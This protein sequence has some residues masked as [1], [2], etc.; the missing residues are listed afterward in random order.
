MKES[1]ID[2]IQTNSLCSGKRA[3]KIFLQAPF[4]AGMNFQVGRPGN[5]FSDH[6]YDIY[7]IDINFV[8]DKISTD[9]G[10]IITA[11]ADGVIN[12]IDYT[13]QG[14]GHYV[15]IQH[16]E[17]FQTVYRH[18]LEEPE[19]INVGDWVPQGT[20]IGRVGGSGGWLPHLH[21]A[22]Y[23]CD[24]D[25]C[26]SI[27]HACPEPLGSIF[28]L[29][30]GGKYTSENYGIGY[31]SVPPD[32]K[33]VKQYDDYNQ[34][35]HDSII[36]LYEKIKI[37]L[38][39]QPEPSSIKGKL[40]ILGGVNLIGSPIGPVIEIGTTF[41]YQEFSSNPFS[42]HLWTVSSTSAI[43][44]RRDTYESFFLVGPIWEHYRNNYH[45]LGLPVNSTYTF[46][47]ENSNVIEVRN[48]FENGS[49]LFDGNAVRKI[50]RNNAAWESL[51]H[52]SQNFSNLKFTRFDESVNTKWEK[53]YT[54]GFKD[55]TSIRWIIELSPISVFEF[56]IVNLQGYLRITRDGRTLVELESPDNVTSHTT[57]LQF[58]VLNKTLSIDFWQHSNEPAV[59]NLGYRS[60]V[61]LLPPIIQKAFAE[62]PSTIYGSDLEPPDVKAVI[63]DPPEYLFEELKPNDTYAESTASVL[64]LDTSGSM[65]ELDITGFSKIEAAQRATR[66]ILDVI[67]A[68]TVPGLSYKH[69]AG[70][71]SFDNHSAIEAEI[72]DDLISVQSI[73]DRLTANGG[74]G[75]ADGL[76]MSLDMLKPVDPSNNKMIVL[77][78]DGMPNIGLNSEQYLEEDQIIEQIMG[79]VSEARSNGICIHAVGL[80][81]PGQVG[82]V[83]GD[84]S[85]NEDLLKRIAAESGC[86]QYYNATTA[87]ELANVFI[88]I[89][90]ASLGQIL[91]SQQGK[92]SQNQEIDLGPVTVAQDQELI[93][94]TLN[95][96]GSQLD[97]DVTDPAG[98]SVKLNYPNANL[99]TTSSLTSLAV[100][101]PMPG[102]WR[103]K[104]FG[105][106]VPKVQTDYNLIFSSRVKP[107]SMIEP[108]IEPVI[109]DTVNIEPVS[110]GS[111][112]V[113]VV[114][115]I[116]ASVV[117]VGTYAGRNKN[118]PAKRI[119][120]Q[121]VLISQ[122]IDTQQ[123]TIPLTSNFVIGRRPTA[124]IYLDD[125]NISRDHAQ[126]Y[127]SEKSW[128]IHDLNSKLGTYLNGK[129]VK[130]AKLSPGDRIKIGSHE[131]I[132]SIK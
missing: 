114:I 53:F 95:W 1:K 105:A 72:T 30:N 48:D 70:L 34:F 51:F 86:G 39:N 7:G 4:P 127:F 77:L 6:T 76:R 87:I 20:P 90:H 71:V 88:E 64:L 43:V 83:S 52:N 117:L 55:G 59:I 93:L 81:M 121:A 44:E 107:I 18:L 58:G 27:E 99:K 62:G 112:A 128:F 110:D 94:I 14:S 103:V 47:M 85:I 26:S 101:D 21:F 120:P 12:K 108:V 129:S 130:I 96:P 10:I 106:D 40:S 124:N 61:D 5:F 122:P 54:P 41:N 126:I 74:T 16:P 38:F 123:Q 11:A 89:R 60:N 37:D 65:D 67:M 29:E 80:G 35:R 115:L 63:F 97:L 98:V 13:Q 132:F 8:N 25:Y 113:L 66:S 118:V 69:Q 22:V 3:D 17:G 104:V 125:L 92:I 32:E 111:G 131:W 9:E 15:I 119:S 24:K 100:T 91:F 19:N 75:M 42:K 102:E 84:S 57:G 31:R 78:S 82:G 46:T 33:Y 50:D 2:Y 56:D 36:N 109:E 79:L 45:E 23:Y 68:E 49:L 73:A 28:A 116:F